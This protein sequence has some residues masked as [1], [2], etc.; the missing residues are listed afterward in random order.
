MQRTLPDWLPDDAPW[1]EFDVSTLK[2]QC[3][4]RNI[5]ADN[6]KAPM[7]K[8]L[9]SYEVARAVE[10]RLIPWWNGKHF[11]VTHVLRY[12]LNCPEPLRW[13][14]W[15]LDSELKDIYRHSYAVSTLLLTK[16]KDQD[17][18]CA[19]CFKVVGATEKRCT[20]CATCGRAMHTECV[21]VA[22][23]VERLANKDRCWRCEDETDWGINNF[24][25]PGEVKF[26]LVVSNTN[27]PARNEEVAGPAKSTTQE[28]NHDT[29]SNPGGIK[30]EEDSSRSTHFGGQHKKPTKAPL[31]TSNPHSATP[32]DVFLSPGSAASV[33]QAPAMSCTSINTSDRRSV[34]LARDRRHLAKESVKLQK[35]AEHA[36]KKM[37]K[38]HRK[39]LKKLEKRAERGLKR[40]KKKSQK[41]EKK[42]RNLGGHGEGSDDV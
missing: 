17:P 7:V 38:R 33:N 15:F 10:K 2:K 8:R 12:V 14:V 23:K 41:L 1:K 31:P 4:A 25:E 29:A 3:E 24:C 18:L 36:F 42:V 22:N 5:L 9:E 30:K 11:Q 35:K 34:K 19:L 37:S 6:L 26:P 39:E 32:S 16:W 13:Q 21:D 20:C 28:A 27:A 40:L